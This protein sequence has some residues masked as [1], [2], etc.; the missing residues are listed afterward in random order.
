MV[1]IDINEYDP[2]SR[3][4]HILDDV[5]IQVTNHHYAAAAMQWVDNHTYRPHRDTGY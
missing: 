4:V 5:M 1:A 3:L 2:L